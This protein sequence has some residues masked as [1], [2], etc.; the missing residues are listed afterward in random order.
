MN[1]KP[2]RVVIEAAKLSDVDRETLDDFHKL[3]VLKEMRKED[4]YV[5]AARTILFDPANQELLSH[6]WVDW[7]DLEKFMLSKGFTINRVTFWN[8]RNKGLFAEDIKSNGVTTLYDADAILAAFTGG[9][10]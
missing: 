1:G 8:Y 6:N 4:A 10:V 2:L 9:K 5:D 3:C 7:D